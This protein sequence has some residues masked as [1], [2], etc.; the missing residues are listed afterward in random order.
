MNLALFVLAHEQA[1]I[2]LQ[3]KAFKAR[4]D[5]TPVTAKLLRDVAYPVHSISLEFIRERE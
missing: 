5:F 3:L 4:V 1:V 2:G